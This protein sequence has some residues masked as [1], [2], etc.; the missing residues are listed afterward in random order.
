M[1]LGR[2]K[3]VLKTK[4]LSVTLNPS[5]PYNGQG[6]IKFEEMDRSFFFFFGSAYVL[7][8]LFLTY[9]LLPLAFCLTSQ[10]KSKY[11]H[12]CVLEVWVH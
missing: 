7:P 9:K 1:C 12:M 4:Q 8:K 5:E 2:E 11:Q 6:I 3:L 10:V